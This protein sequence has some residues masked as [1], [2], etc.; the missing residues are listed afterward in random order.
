MVPPAVCSVVFSPV[1][2]SATSVIK[3]ACAPLVIV[4]ASLVPVIVMTMSW[5]TVP[6]LPSA[7][8]TV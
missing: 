8:V 6:P 4:G 5:V 3:P 1:A 2:P 7:I